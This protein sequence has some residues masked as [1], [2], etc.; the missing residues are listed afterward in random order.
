[1]LA[2][3][4]EKEVAFPCT[5][6]DRIV[7]ATTEEDK[8]TAEVELYARDEGLVVTEPYCQWVIE[9]VFPEGRPAWGQAGVTFSLEVKAFEKMK[10]R[11]LNGSHSTL[12]YLGY[13]AGKKTIAECIQ[14]TPLRMLIQHLM[15]KEILPTVDIPKNFNLKDYMDALILRFA[16]TGLNHRLDQIAMDGSQKLPPRLLDPIRDHLSE[17]GSANIDVLSLA[18]AGW[19]RYV[20]GRDEAGSLI[21]ISDPM[22]GKLAERTHN[23]KRMPDEVV[24]NLLRLKKVFGIDLV[25][26]ELFKKKVKGAF[27]D[28]CTLGTRTTILKTL[29]NVRYTEPT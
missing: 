19:M 26:N 20:C 28:I 8:I 13:L 1:K 11:F 16:N 2:G 29:E 23:F 6:V 17:S 18:V 9:D 22:V 24:E 5:M 25:E 21:T 7:P 14:W 3:W 4:I 10:L 12:A 15:K 27:R